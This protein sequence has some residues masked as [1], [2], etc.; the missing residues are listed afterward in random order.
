M[1]TLEDAEALARSMVN[2]GKR[3]GRNV[4]AVLTGM[5]SPLGCAV[6]NS[7]EVAEA[8]AVLKGESCGELRDVCVVLAAEMVS[9]VHGISTGEA[10]AKVLDV[11]DSGA[12][13]EKMK[14]WI[15]ASGGDV[16]Y[17]ED[18]ELFTKAKFEKK[19]LSPS[20]GYITKMDAEKIGTASVV[21]G[22]GRE[23]K[24]DLI[25]YSAGIV[26]CAHTG[27]FLMKGDVI[28]TLYTNKETAL[29]SAEKLYLEAVTLGD[30]KPD[31]SPTVY[32]IIR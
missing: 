5:D 14:E 8:V 26:L 13:F 4:T 22:A 3:C 32:K 19:I 18:T 23:K 1:K 28:C 12:A 20:D 11:L 6:G 16:A 17:V 27:D 15:A 24:D 10:E 9:L 30:S 21:L 7:L 29:A 31:V 2:I 25:D